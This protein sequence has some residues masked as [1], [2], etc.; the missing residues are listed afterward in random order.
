MEVTYNIVQNTSTQSHALHYIYCN[1]HV[2]WIL[3]MLL[4]CW[5]LLL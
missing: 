5:T 1:L 2:T 4:K 3:V